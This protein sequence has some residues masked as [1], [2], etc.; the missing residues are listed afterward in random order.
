[1]KCVCVGIIHRLRVTYLK[2]VSFRFCSIFMMG[3]QES[4]SSRGKHGPPIG[5]G[6]DQESQNPPQVRTTVYTIICYIN[7]DDTESL[8][9]VDCSDCSMDSLDK[10]K[11]I[12][13]VLK[14]GQQKRQQFESYVTQFDDESFCDC[15]DAQTSWKTFPLCD[16]HIKGV[17]FSNPPAL[18]IQFMVFIQFISNSSATIPGSF[19]SSVGLL[20]LKLQ[21]GPIG[22]PTDEIGLCLYGRINESI[23]GCNAFTRARGWGQEMATGTPGMIR[24]QSFE[25]TIL[26]E[27]VNFKIA[28]NRTH[29][30]EFAHQTNPSSLSHL[31]VATGSSDITLS[32]VWIEDSI[33]V[34]AAPAPAQPPPYGAPPGA[35]GAPYGPPPPGPPPGA[36]PGAPPGPHYGA[37][38]PGA[39]P[40]YAPPPYSPD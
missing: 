31:N 9:L 21:S 5:F 35:P 4:S 14:E 6:S 38:P 30:T 28:L 25:I 34:P 32:T 37:T 33:P 1:M 36:P 26:C 29:L 39:P 18:F 3:N 16:I 17:Q 20:V 19:L 24:G 12:E 10:K 27:P 22:D 2:I 11:M 7:N 15:G 13:R 8:D 23:V 40:S